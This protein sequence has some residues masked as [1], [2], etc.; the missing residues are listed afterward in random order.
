MTESPTYRV[1]PSF[2]K[3]HP[4]AVTLIDGVGV[5][6]ADADLV[7]ETPGTLTHP[8]V[9]RVFRAVTQSDMKHLFETEHHPAIEI[10]ENESTKPTKLK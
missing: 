1:K 10:V 7:D 2:K 9:R 8:P 3:Q 5:V 6:L 4:N